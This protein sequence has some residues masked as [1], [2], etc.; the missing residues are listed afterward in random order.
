MEL[1]LIKCNCSFSEA[2]N[3]VLHH[4]DTY[5]RRAAYPD[6]IYV[7]VGE[8]TDGNTMIRN[9]IID[10]SNNKSYIDMHWKNTIDIESA[11]ANDWGVY[12]VVS[13]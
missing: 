1:N 11:C 2:V 8:D 9:F 12:K 6:K 10:S 13:E 4:C 3:C 5:I 7:S